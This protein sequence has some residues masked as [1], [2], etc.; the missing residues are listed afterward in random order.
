MNRTLL[1]LFIRLFDVVI[2]QTEQFR[3]DDPERK[4]FWSNVRRDVQQIKNRVTTEF[5]M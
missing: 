1:R 5:D 2:E 4:E 3:Y